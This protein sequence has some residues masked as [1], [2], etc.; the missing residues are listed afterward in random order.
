M[1]TYNEQEKK[2]HEKWWLLGWVAPKANTHYQWMSCGN[3]QRL[4]GGFQWCITWC[5]KD[6]N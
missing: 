2:K 1:A 5:T 6:H 4:I 3:V